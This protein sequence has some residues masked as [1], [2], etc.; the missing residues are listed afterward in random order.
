MNSRVLRIE[1]RR[2]AAPWAGLVAGAGALGFLALL[3][4]PWWG[5]T[6]AGTSQWTPM[7]LLT[8]TTLYYVW[9]LVVGIGALQGLR[10]A[11][12]RTTEL[13]ATTPRPSW[14]RAMLPAGATAIALV[15]GFGLLTLWGG[16]QV[17]LG[18]GSYTHLGWLPISLVGALALVA[19]ALF[20]MGV[21]R[22]LPSV[23]TPP[24]LV[25]A[26]LAA[27][28]L[29]Q[30]NADG[31][32]PSGSAPNRVSL[33]SPAAP[34]PREMLL[35]LASQVHLGQ[36]VWLLGLLATG[37]ALLVAVGHR[38][39]LLASVPVLV[40]A[41]LALSVLPAAPRQSYVIDQAAAALV[42]DG[43]VCVTQAHAARLEEM[44]PRGREALLLLSRVLGDKA[45]D[46]VREETTLRAS[47]DQRKLAA[48]TV[49]VDFDDPLLAGRE[50]R[51]LTRYLVAQGLAPNCSARTAQESGGLDGVVAQ[52][53]VAGW[54]LGDRALEPLEEKATDEYSR[55][56]WKEGE[57]AWAG[58]AAAQPAEQRARIAAAHQES[59]SCTYEAIKALK[60]GA[61]R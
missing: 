45:P 56:A 50:G 27:I 17:F 60:G 49:L 57:D 59:L 23:I 31:V 58:L 40:G 48:G 2:S 24:L 32:V 34:P 14:S 20:G 8:R 39:R 26:C 15:S 6:A 53:I 36:T 47:G 35:T 5:G 54:A 46:S 41:A 1:L 3:D 16:F 7:A 18:G 21:A 38:A 37:F 29:T 12:S 44:A 9:P 61:S 42:C 19:G 10:D 43:P 28:I 51:E 30:Q 33:L 55:A 4:D 11:R 52:S 13:L 22:V 25:V